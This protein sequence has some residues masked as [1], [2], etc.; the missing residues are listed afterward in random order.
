MFIGGLCNQIDQITIQVLG[1]RLEIDGYCNELKV[2][3]E[4]HGLQHYE[5]VAHFHRG[6]S[7]LKNQQ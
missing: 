4:F 3:F 1:G 6:K 5:H 7:T 2:G